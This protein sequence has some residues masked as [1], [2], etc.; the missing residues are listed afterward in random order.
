M[1]I[2]SVTHIQALEGAIRTRTK[3]AK[4]AGRGGRVIRPRAS[5]PP[6]TT[7]RLWT[8]MLVNEVAADVLRCLDRQSLDT[9]EIASNSF[10][11]VIVTFL[12]DFPLRIV[13]SLTVCSEDIVGFVSDSGQEASAPLEMLGRLLRRMTVREIRFECLLNEPVFDA[14]L[15]HIDKFK[16]SVCCAPTMYASAGLMERAFEELLFCRVI[17][18]KALSVEGVDDLWA[19]HKEAPFASLACIQKCELLHIYDASMAKGEFYRKMVPWLNGGGEKKKLALES[20]FSSIYLSTVNMDLFRGFQVAASPSE[21]E[22]TLITTEPDFSIGSYERR[23]NERT[24]EE[25][26]RRF[27][28]FEAGGNSRQK[29]TFIRRLLDTNQ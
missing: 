18:I 29:A 14:L 15:P 11:T 19:Y 27:E 9:A 4:N 26:I 17:R 7:V 24:H 22:L 12:D 3:T 25:L 13:Q 21:Y 5:V 6:T 10:N 20:D 2:V 16:N 1:A 8:E 28:R 23:V